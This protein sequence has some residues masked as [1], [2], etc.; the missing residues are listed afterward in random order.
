MQQKRAKMWLHEVMVQTDIL[1]FMISYHASVRN[2]VS[3]Q[4]RYVPQVL[5]IWTLYTKGL[6]CAFF[7][8]VILNIFWTY[9]FARNFFIYLYIC[10]YV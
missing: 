5:L 6:S 10:M 4:L 3:R 7:A 1:F 8:R 2:G 9:L